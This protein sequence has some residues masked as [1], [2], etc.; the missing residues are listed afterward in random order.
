MIEHYALCERKIFLVYLGTDIELVDKGVTKA[1]KTKRENPY[2]S[3]IFLGWEKKN[4]LCRHAA[5]KHSWKKY[6]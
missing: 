3:E 6:V 2:M 5:Q 4:I 1:V